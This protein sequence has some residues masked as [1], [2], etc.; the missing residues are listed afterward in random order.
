M[1]GHKLTLSENNEALVK[2]GT[3]LSQAAD[4]PVAFESLVCDILSSARA[5][6]PL[7]D[8]R[9]ESMV[10]ETLPSIASAA[11]SARAYLASYVEAMDEP[12]LA[13][14]EE[15]R[16]LA[17][18]A[19]AAERLDWRGG[20]SLFDLGIARDAFERFLERADIG[21]GSSF[22]V[23]AQQ[24]GAQPPIWHGRR[25]PALG[26]FCLTPV[27][28][29]SW[30]DGL[31]TVLA[32]EFDLSAREIA[33]LRALSDGLSPEEVALRDERALS[34]IRQSIKSVLA[35]L[36]VHS[37]SHAIAL[38]A[39]MASAT[40]P[41][42]PVLDKSQPVALFNAA[43]PFG[44]NI[45]WRR[46]GVPGGIPVL[47][48]HGTLFGIAELVAERRF[49][50][51]L[52]LD[53]VACERPGYGRTPVCK[54]RNDAMGAAVADMVLT[55]DASGLDRVIIL[56]HDTGLA[57]AH[58]L[59][60][61]C[62]ERIA[63]IVAVS[64]VIP[65]RAVAQTTAMPPQQQVFAWA[66]RHAPWLVEGLTRIG[67]ERMRR[68]GPSG[69]PHAVFAGAPRDLEVSARPDILPAVNAAYAFNAG[70][71]AAGFRMDVTVANADWS[72]DLKQISCPL[73]LIHGTENRT[74]PVAAVRALAAQHGDRITLDCIEGEGHTLPLAQPHLGLRAAFAMAARQGLA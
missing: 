28:G 59:A 20:G 1:E 63:G 51:D 44:R 41:Q 5:G 49:A 47:M 19:E 29:K 17:S 34:T 56:A 72:A 69:W 10:R 54:V 11:R 24:Q 23:G 55:L 6:A 58:A 43:D 38:V 33:I 61:H 18:N 40:L 39:A 65:M 60:M 9:F 14:D 35:K 3:S 64:P 71:A 15:G 46:Y 30:T 16:I 53:I 70:Q 57:F 74:V 42:A 13:F 50:L 2:L 68:L 52:G 26:C 67:I 62:P 36:N 22:L 31:R 37:R 27:M 8:G 73:H 4:D 32:S 45:G 66:A 12:A 21:D 48:I 7:A 25:L